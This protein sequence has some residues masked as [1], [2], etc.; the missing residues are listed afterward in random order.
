MKTGKR[1]II[2]NKRGKLLYGD[3][4]EEIIGLCFKVHNQYG[5][6]Q[7][8][9][10]YQKALEEKLSISNLPFTREESIKIK[11]EDTGKVLGLHR[12][13]FVVRLLLGYVDVGLALLFLKQM[14]S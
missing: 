7:K 1:R 8:E 13:D 2:K 3:L 12:L 14:K 5:S 6:G 4:T 10:V 9:S 11:S